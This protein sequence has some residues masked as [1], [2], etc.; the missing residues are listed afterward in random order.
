MSALKINFHQLRHFIRHFFSAKRKGHGI[1]SPFAYKLCEEVFYNEDAFYDFE[2][3]KKVRNHL[4]ENKQKIEVQDFGA[5]SKTFTSS[6]RQ[7]KDIADRG[8]STTLQSELFYK[9]INFLNCSHCVELGTSIGLNT[10]YLAQANKK[11]QVISVEGSKNL[12]DFASALATSNSIHNIDFVASTFEKALPDV[13]TKLPALDLL[14]IDG[15]HR[16]EATLAYFQQTLP[17]VHNNTVI[18]F[19]DIYWSA[20]MTKAWEEIKKHSS[21]TLSI[22]AFYFG[23]VF[24]KKEV[25]EKQELK[26]FI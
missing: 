14:Y 5:G 22:D 24:F 25:K 2:T 6:S 17:K 8:V 7:V 4:L 10:L 19:D 13:L 15:N 23:M 16:Y 12:S 18:I 3:L 11:G 21:V 9:L 20:G 26:L 1:H